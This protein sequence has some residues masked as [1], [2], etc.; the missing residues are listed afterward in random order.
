MKEISSLKSKNTPKL[1]DL[2]VSHFRPAIA[3]FATFAL[4]IFLSVVC[5]KYPFGDYSTS[6]SDLSAQYAPFLAMFRNRMDIAPG[7]GGLL[8]HLMYS[9]DIGMGSNYMATFGYYLASPLNLLFVFIDSSYID[10]FVLF[11]MI[12]K[13]S[14]S[15]AF[16]CMFMSERAK[17]KK[18]L[19][20]ILWGVIYSFTSYS[21]AFIFSIMWLDGYMLL[22]LLLYFTEKFITKDK[23]AG[24][25]ITLL[26]LFLSNFYIAYMVGIFVFI[27]LIVRMGSLGMYKNIKAA[28]GKIIRFIAI[29]V[30]DAMIMCVVLIPVGLS[31]LANGDPTVSSAEEHYVLYSL[32]DMLDH[33]FIG[34]PGEF[35]D[36]MPANLP[37]FFS[38]LLVTALITVFFVS[39]AFDR[40]DKIRYLLCLAG[41][42]VSTAVY[43]IDVAWQVFDSPNWFWHRHSFVF[44][45][46]FLI[47][48]AKVYEEFSSVTRREIMVSFGILT[49][50][51]FLAQSFGNMSEDKTFLFNLGFLIVLFVI[52]FFM[53]K[54][55]WG[56]GFE[57]MPSIMPLILTIIV[58]FEVV[59]IQPL[60]STDLSAFT[61][62][63]G[64]S[65][66][67]RTSI[68]AMRDLGEVQT[69]TSQKNRAFRAENEVIS[70]YTNSN[71]V[72][73][74]SNMFGA[75]HGV[76]FF[77]SSSNKSLH[78]FIKQLGFPVNYNYFATSYTYAAPDSDAF[79]SVGALTT[80]REYSDSV[81]VNDDQFDIGYHFY[82]NKHVLPLAFAADKGAMVFDYYQLEKASENKDYFAFRNLWFKSLFPDVFTENYFITLPAESV[83]G[84]DVINAMTTPTGLTTMAKI[85]AEAESSDKADASSEGDPSASADKD[86]L[87]LEDL[88]AKEAEKN[89][90]TYYR[91]NEEVPMYIE[92]RTKAPRTGEM[93]FNLTAPSTTGTMSVYVNDIFISH[94]SKGTYFSQVY[95]L[96]TYNEGD[97]I[98]VTITS[99]DDKFTYLDARFG[100]FDF[101]KF[102]EQFGGI[103]RDKVIVNEA[104][105]GYV[106]LTTDI[107]D[108]ELVITTVPYEKGWTLMIDGA[109]STIT[110]YQEAF[111]AFEV[112]SGSHTCELKFTAPGFKT[113]AMVSC[114]GLVILP[115]F[116]IID[117]KKNRAG[118]GDGP[119]AE[120]SGK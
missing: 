99:D 80:M 9:F 88:A 97:D 81:F 23:K 107:T 84:P 94:A 25:I 100:Y 96:G 69:L 74:H 77:N 4:Y 108:R 59:Y 39:K 83:E 28:I 16:M 42:Y 104:S 21:T 22:P 50:L 10:A 8:S 109:E 95:R 101:G 114:A 115:V 117:R 35:G 30:I 61:L 52:L 57:D 19:W 90:V 2:S 48:A 118:K 75:F 71:Y 55:D 38:G 6:I 54:K 62:Y 89:A 79:L 1:K 32:K 15:S 53:N 36:I 27:Y 13:M 12:S 46:L 111:V 7:S 58:V 14:F 31:T 119:A 70:D 24:L 44:I 91:S 29:A 110:P 40:K 105:D 37:F 11:L 41:V 87:G 33:I 103:N 17:T 76:S 20:P 56:K 113:G 26:V 45:P 67:Y 86:R 64:S 116:L 73:E 120:K 34:T 72:V 106:N 112:P 98:K 93:Y 78:R 49:G 65:E 102:G 66:Q 85:K 3:F 92:Y 63:N 82:A 68:L 60:L 18:C 5:Q 47:I 51:L 43:W